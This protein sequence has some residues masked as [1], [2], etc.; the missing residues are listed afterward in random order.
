MAANFYPD[1]DPNPNF[2]EVEE[3]VQQFWKDEQI[4]EATIEQRP[5]PACEEFVFYDGPPFANGLPHYGH[6]VTGFVKDVVPRYQTMRGKRVERRFGWD[7][8]GLPAEM[9]AESDLGVSG[10]KAILEFGMDKFNDHCRASVLEF[11]NE[12]EHYVTRQARWVDFVNDY[13]TMDLS[14]MESVMWAFKQ[15]WDKGWI[16]EDYRVVP[17]SWAVESPLSNFETRLDDSYRERQ[18]PAITVA[19]SLLPRPGD[20]MPMK[21]LAWTTTPWTLP[22]N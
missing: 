18:D 14:F 11:T 22:S 1:V 10:R 7:C 19:F 16:Y 4:F 17:Y 9:Q 15:L 5:T 20:P 13:K 3:K 12:W 2:P 6:I 8:H 21:L